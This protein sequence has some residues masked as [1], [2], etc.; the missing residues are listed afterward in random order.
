LGVAAQW[1]ADHG[2]ETWVIVTDAWN[3]AG[4][5]YRGLGFEPDVCNARAYRAPS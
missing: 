2:C 1:A 5:I 4:R 3:P